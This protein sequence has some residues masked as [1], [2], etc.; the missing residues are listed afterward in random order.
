MIPKIIPIRPFIYATNLNNPN[1]IQNLL[2]SGSYEQPNYNDLFTY[3]SITINQT[4]MKFIFK[5]GKINGS[6]FEDGLTAML[7]SP[8]LAETW[9][10]PLQ[11]PYC[12]SPYSVGNIK[13]LQFNSQVSWKETQDHSKW[14]YATQNNYVCF[15]DMNRMTSQWKRGGAFY[16]LNSPLL[17]QAM[18]SITLQTD[19]TCASATM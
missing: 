6:I 16:C 2:A 9:G 19:T 7:Q 18:L 4:Q 14:A 8:I 12:G 3:S 11:V 17:K 1:S 5:N 15:G 13:L 10:R